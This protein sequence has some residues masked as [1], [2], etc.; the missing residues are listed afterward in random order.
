[1]HKLEEENAYFFRAYYIRLKLKKHIIIF[2]HLLE[3]QYHLMKYPM[4]PKLPMGPIQNRVH[5]MPGMLTTYPWDTQFYSNVQWG[6]QVSLIWIPWY[7]VDLLGPV[8]EIF[9]ETYDRYEPTNDV[10]ADSCFVSTQL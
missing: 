3:H 1:M 4:P 10:E 2:N 6:L 5:P 8:D 9:Y 7:G